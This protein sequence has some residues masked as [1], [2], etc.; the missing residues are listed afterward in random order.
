MWELEAL[1]TDIGPCNNLL[2]P[3]PSLIE[4]SID[5][6]CANIVKFTLRTSDQGDSNTNSSSSFPSCRPGGARVQSPPSLNSEGSSYTAC[7]SESASRNCLSKRHPHNTQKS[8]MMNNSVT[9]AGSVRVVDDDPEATSPPTGAGSQWPWSSVLLSNTQS[10]QTP[11][12]IPDFDTLNWSSDLPA[13]AACDIVGNISNSMGMPQ[14][15]CTITAADCH[16]HL[17]AAANALADSSL[18]T[19]SST[20]SGVADNAL[21]SQ[22]YLSGPNGETMQGLQNCPV[23][24]LQDLLYS[25]AMR[26]HN[27]EYL[28]SDHLK[29]MEEVPTWDAPPKNFTFQGDDM[30]MASVDQKPSPNLQ[31]QQLVDDRLSSTAST[32]PDMEHWSAAQEQ[33]HHAGSQT[34]SVNVF[35]EMQN[36]PQFDHSRVKQEYAGSYG[37]NSPSTTTS[38]FWLH[39]FGAEPY[40]SD[41]IS[42]QMMDQCGSKPLFRTLPASSNLSASSTMLDEYL[43]GCRWPRALHPR[44]STALQHALPAGHIPEPSA[45][46]IAFGS[47]VPRHALDVSSLRPELRQHLLSAASNRGSPLQFMQH[48]LEG[49]PLHDPS[50]NL[51]AIQGHVEDVREASSDPKRNTGSM[52]SSDNAS[53]GYFKRPRVETTPPAVPFKQ[54][55]KEKL[56]DRITTLQ[57]LVSPFGKTDTASVLLEA[58]G[59]IKFLQEQVQA[60]SSPYMKSTITTTSQSDQGKKSWNAEK[61]QDTDEPK[62]DLRSRGLCLVPLSCTVHVANDN[63]A[64][65]WTPTFGGSFR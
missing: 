8:E 2:Y 23:E 47:S 50:S 64:D 61:G 13:A 40:K 49:K 12:S 34:A 55:R 63:G 51:R 29:K 60:L 41:A 46:M 11:S 18:S 25:R 20:L 10:Q 17:G 45:Q 52:P 16:P 32:L 27:S 9:S 53:E 30:N 56:G 31:Y 14:P 38:P 62:Q 57:Q 7:L 6:S 36:R 35:S 26:H 58:I 1:Q 19:M 44:F 48:S 4:T 21:W 3:Y 43:N 59:Y 33:H 65:Y 22:V 24:G 15:S 5:K 42:A 39:G 54:V 37:C 28:L